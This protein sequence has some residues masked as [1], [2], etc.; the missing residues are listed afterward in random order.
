MVRYIPELVAWLVGIVLAVLMLR[1]GG[2]R[3]EK[4]F[5]SGCCLIFVTSL[6]APLLSQLVQRV[7]SQH[8]MSNLA[9]AQTMSWV[10][11]P[12]GILSLAGLVCLVWAFWVQ[13]RAKRQE[14]A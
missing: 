3:I 7:T 2:G 1:R 8:D 13:F 6:A 10:S 5:L 14:P 12:M 9:I 4:L 11:L